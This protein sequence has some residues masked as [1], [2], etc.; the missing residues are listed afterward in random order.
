MMSWGS[1]RCG[2][3]LTV[4]VMHRVDDLAGRTEAELQLSRL[5]GGQANGGGEIRMMK[6]G[7]FPNRPPYV[8]M[9]PLQ[10]IIAETIGGLPTSQKV[11]DE[12]R[13]LTDSL[14]SEFRVLL[15][16]THSDITKISGERIA[17]AIHKVRIGDIVVDPGYDGVFGVVKIWEEKKE[18]KPQDEKKQ[19][20]FF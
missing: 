13:K 10:E 16:S 14:G 3:K 6:S 4:G 2:R 7:L 11:Q 5:S 1:F 8:N 20:S 19:L 18:Q 17:Q 12:Y 9:V 15:E